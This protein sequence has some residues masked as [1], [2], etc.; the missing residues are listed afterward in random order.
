MVS[1]AREDLLLMRNCAAADAKSPALSE[2][3]W[4]AVAGAGSYQR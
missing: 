1:T 3:M 2:R 4:Q